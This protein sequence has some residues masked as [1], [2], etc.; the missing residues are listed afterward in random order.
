[1]KTNATFSTFIQNLGVQS[2]HFNVV[3]I[4]WEKCSSLCGKINVKTFV[5][6]NGHISKGYRMCGMMLSSL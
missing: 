5:H 4:S 2:P 6:S 1:M 3:L